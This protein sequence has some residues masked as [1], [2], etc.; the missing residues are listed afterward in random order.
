MHDNP[1]AERGPLGGVARARGLDWQGVRT[2]SLSY[3][4]R[5]GPA[6]VAAVEPC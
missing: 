1:R 5:A 2:S 6:N 3:A 4:R